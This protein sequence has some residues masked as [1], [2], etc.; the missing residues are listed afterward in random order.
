MRKRCLQATLLLVAVA[1]SCGR[2]G[3]L[4]APLGQADDDRA[5]ASPEG[6]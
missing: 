4:P 1:A 5:G 2:P 3:A 6:A